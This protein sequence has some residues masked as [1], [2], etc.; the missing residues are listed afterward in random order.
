VRPSREKKNLR[1]GSLD[2]RKKAI[3]TLPVKKRYEP[4]EKKLV[5]N[6]IGEVVSPEKKRVGSAVHLGKAEKKAHS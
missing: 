2:S 4:T 6:K 3:M 1:E 5:K